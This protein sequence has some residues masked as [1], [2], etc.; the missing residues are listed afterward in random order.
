MK[1]T[2]ADW[3][4]LMFNFLATFKMD[5]LASKK[6]NCV[7]KKLENFVNVPFIQ[8]KWEAKIP[9]WGLYDPLPW[10]GGRQ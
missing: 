7:F 5:G 10:K 2:R 6:Y 1:Q 9:R 8:L 3:Y 4:M